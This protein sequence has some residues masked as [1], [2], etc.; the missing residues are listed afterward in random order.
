[1]IDIA[2]KG[3]QSFRCY[4]LDDIIFI[5]SGFILYQPLQYILLTRQFTWILKLFIT[6]LDFFLCVWVLGN[7]EL[8]VY[9]KGLDVW[10]GIM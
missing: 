5:A 7:N 1:M 10:M 9:A 4:I 2:D 6:L 3:G 8:K